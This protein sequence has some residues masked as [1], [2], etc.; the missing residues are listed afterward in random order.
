MTYR[1]R[2]LRIALLAVAGTLLGAAALTGCATSKHDMVAA[3]DGKVSV[4]TK[5]YDTVRTVM[6]KQGR[7]FGPAV[8]RTII[9]NHCDECN[10][11]MTIYESG[12]VLKV[13]CPHC[14]PEGVDCDRC[15][16]KT[17]AG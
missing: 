2:P 16:P 15:V 4:C 9:T 1:T 17:Q 5:C 7:R 8:E 13:R 14:A 6:D 12:G 3:P 10:S 11:D